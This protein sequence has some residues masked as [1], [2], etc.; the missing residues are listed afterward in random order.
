MDIPQFKAI[1][2]IWKG[3]ENKALTGAV[4][5][6]Q[7]ESIVNLAKRLVQLLMKKLLRKVLK[8]N[9]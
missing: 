8:I 5:K 9:F 7:A 3:I 4:R 2:N 1:S 6:A